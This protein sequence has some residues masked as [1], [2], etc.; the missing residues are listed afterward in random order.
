MYQLSVE[1]SSDLRWEM[2]TRLGTYYQG[3]NVFIPE[4]ITLFS[5]LFVAQVGLSLNSSVHCTLED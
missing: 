1:F 2:H 5:L 3:S 4:L